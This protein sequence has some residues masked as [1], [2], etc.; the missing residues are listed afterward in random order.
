LVGL[1]FLRKFAIIEAGQLPKIEVLLYREEDGSVPLR[2]WLDGLERKAQAKCVASLERLEDMGHELRRPEADLLRDKIYEL[3]TRHG[4]VNLRMLHFFHGRQ[5]VV[6][7]HGLTKEDEV[8]PRGIDLAI[9]RKA[10]FEKAPQKHTFRG[11]K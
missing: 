9:Q 3:R 11:E 5:A 10:C 2:E 4:R 6:V 1:Y 7:S 8:P